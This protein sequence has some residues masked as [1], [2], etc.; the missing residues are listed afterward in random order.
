MKKVI[1]LILVTAIL[2]IGCSSINKVDENKV[3]DVSDK[4]TETIIDTVGK[5]KAKR[6]ESHTINAENLSM[7]DI[8]SSVGKIN[9]NS[10]DSNDAIVNID[11]TAQSNSKD[12]AQKL[13]DEFVYTVNEE[14]K[15]IAVDT[16]YNDISLKGENIS[17]DLFITVPKHIESITISLNV[18]DIDIKNIN[19]I[20]EVKN[21]VGEITIENSKAS[22]NIKN[23]VGDIDLINVSA[24][25]DSSF[26]AN[27]GEIKMY[28]DDIKDANT[29]EAETGVG[30]IDI[31]LPDDS[32]YKAVINEFMEKE[33]IERNKDEKTKIIITTG[34]GE[35]DFN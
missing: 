32:S 35:V 18:G 12:K 11:I 34:V 17:T 23:D 5:E 21:N 30:D 19:G 16:S 31:S 7:L 13:V 4:I 29:I 28:F 6:Q 10:H 24:V 20:Y 22:Y 3:K 15:S 1:S 14:S 26:K 2:L 25:N 9:I 8:K 33:R 27:T